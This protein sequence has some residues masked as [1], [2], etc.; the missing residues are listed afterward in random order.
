MLWW[1]FEN[2]CSIGQVSSRIVDSEPYVLSFIRMPYS[3]RFLA[4]AAGRGHTKTA[5]NAFVTMK[6]QRQGLANERPDLGPLYVFLLQKAESGLAV[7]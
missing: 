3:T 1:L 4:V 2:I 6:C 5:L 7:L